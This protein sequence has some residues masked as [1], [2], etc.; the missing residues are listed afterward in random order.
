MTP[1]TIS[2]VNGALMVL[3][4]ILDTDYQFVVLCLPQK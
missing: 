1:M 4:L 2:T 3:H